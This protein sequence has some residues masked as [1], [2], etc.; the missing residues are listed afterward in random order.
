MRFMSRARPV[1]AGAPPPNRADITAI[2]AREDPAPATIT[3]RRHLS[4]STSTDRPQPSPATHRT[5]TPGTP[6]QPL[7]SRR[8]AQRSTAGTAPATTAPTQPRYHAGGGR[9]GRAS[10]GVPMGRQGLTPLL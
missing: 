6:R 3:D 10:L 4:R 8:R 9:D 5:G 2:P 7:P 1:Q